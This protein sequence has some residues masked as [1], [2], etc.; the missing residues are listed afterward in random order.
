MDPKHLFFDERFRGMCVHCGANA[1]TRDHVPSLALLDK[2]YPADLPVVPSC[3][4][5]NES[6]SLDEQ[7]AACLLDCVVNGSVAACERPAVQRQLEEKPRLADRLASARSVG[8]D[9]QVSWRPETDRITKVVLKLARGHA[10]FE[11]AEPLLDE[12][13][14][15]LAVPLELMA[16]DE[17]EQFE[18]LADVELWPEVG[19]RAFI[20]RAKSWSETPGWSVVQDGRYRYYVTRSGSGGFTVRFVLSEYLAG[21]VTW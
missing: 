21:A 3:G 4:S 9:G 12:P 1:D 7:Y 17:R 6:F 11:G 8:D 15:I 18:S 20:A 13:E 10:A 2:P 16:E 5:C 14:R 19:S